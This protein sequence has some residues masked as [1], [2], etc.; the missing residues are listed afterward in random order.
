MINLRCK[1]NFRKKYT[2]RSSLICNRRERLSPRIRHLYSNEY[3]NIKNITKKMR[4]N[5]KTCNLKYIAKQNYLTKNCRRQ[6][7]K[8]TQAYKKVEYTCAF[9]SAAKAKHNK[10]YLYN[11]FIAYI[12]VIRL[13]LHICR[14]R[15]SYGLT[16]D[17]GH[18]IYIKNTITYLWRILA[19]M[20]NKDL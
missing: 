16:N 8:L 19:K 14:L 7:I 4:S 15:K 1:P 18:Y 12:E 20:Q 2:T 5:P 6:L 9:P 10:V 17:R 13:R 3:F 11:A